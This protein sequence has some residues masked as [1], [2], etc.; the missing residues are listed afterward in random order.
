LE[1]ERIISVNVIIMLAKTSLGST[2]TTLFI[3][4]I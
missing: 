2:Q 4:I 1:F 3:I